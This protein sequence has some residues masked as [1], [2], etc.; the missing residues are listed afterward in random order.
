ML[1]HIE[2]LLAGNDHVIV[3]GLG[4]FAVQKSSAVIRGN[5]ILPPRATLGFNPMVN[6]NDGLLALEISRS[7]GISYRD[8]SSMID[9]AVTLFL[10][11][12]T[13]DDQEEFGN[14]GS[15]TLNYD[16]HLLFSP[17][18]HLPFL[19]LNLGQRPVRLPAP[20]K[21]NNRMLEVRFPAYRIMRYAAAVVF[22][23]ALLYSSG[24][25][26]TAVRHDQANLNMF[27]SINWEQLYAPAPAVSY[28]DS[29]LLSKSVIPYP[30]DDSTSVESGTREE[31]EA[32]LLAV[33]PSPYSLVVGVFQ[34][35]ATA[36]RMAGT[37]IS[38]F[39]ET[40]VTTEGSYYKVTICNFEDIK[41]AISYMDLLR[42]EDPRFTDVWVIKN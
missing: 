23:L 39:P 36:L 7:E 28:A 13:A 37:F 4:V 30:Q 17:A 26:H 38:E 5:F 18:G 40:A 21:V 8:A 16:G 33:Q 9:R 25:N 27:K 6:H 10:E 32:D 41:A 22:V 1:R 3:P 42:R 35:E 15:F 24:V 19:P 31:E 2:R 11:E 20:V 34:T 29:S 12:V 14:L